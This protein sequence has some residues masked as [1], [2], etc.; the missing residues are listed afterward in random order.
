MITQYTQISFYVGQSATPIS[1]LSNVSNVDKIYDIDS[2]GNYIGYL[3][4]FS[5][6][7]FLQGLT[8][9]QPSTGYIVVTKSS[10]TLP[11]QLFPDETEI[12]TDTE[13]A[14]V[15]GVLQGGIDNVNLFSNAVFQTLQTASGVL[16]GEITVVSGD[17]SF[18]S[19]ELITASGALRDSIDTLDTSVTDLD[20]K[21]LNASG[22]LQSQVTSNSGNI[23]IVSGIMNT[24]IA[25]L[26]VDVTNL[27]NDLDSVSGEMINRVAASGQAALDHSATVSGL[28]VASSGNLSNRI[29]DNVSNISFVS[30]EIITASGALKDQ[31]DNITVDLAPTEGRIDF[32]SGELIT[33]SGALRADITTAESDIDFVS[34]ELITASGALRTDVDLKATDIMSIARSGALQS[35]T[36]TVSGIL[37]I[38][39]T[40]ASGALN[41]DMIASGT[42]LQSQITTIEN[43]TAILAILQDIDDIIGGTNATD[44]NAFLTSVN[45]ASA[46]VSGEIITAS[47]ALRAD[48]NLKATEVDSVARSG[49]LQSQITTAS[50]ALQADI[51]ALSSLDLEELGNLADILGSN[52]DLAALISGMESDITTNASDID[53]VSGELI[54]A[55]G[56]LRSGIN[57]VDTDVISLSGQMVSLTDAAAQSLNFNVTVFND[58][59]VNK[60]RFNGCGTTDDNNPDLYLHKGLTYYLNVDAATHP[61]WIKTESGIGTDNVQSDG[62]TNNGAENGTVIFTVPQDAPSILYYNCQYHELMAGKIYTA[63]DSV[64]SVNGGLA[65]TYSPFGTTT[66]PPTATTTAAPTYSNSV[67]STGAGLVV[68]NAFVGAG[69]EFMTA[70][71][72]YTMNWN[73]SSLTVPSTWA[74]SSY[75]KHNIYKNGVNVVSVAFYALGFL[76]DTD[77]PAYELELPD[78]STYTI[79]WNDGTLN[80]GDVYDVNL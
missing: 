76:N 51:D 25:A 69:L 63:V 59:G 38:D 20:T 15:S 36:T 28:L 65:D 78:G 42:S 48:V 46:F 52:A 47:G 29:S 72:G 80:S 1:G 2:N 67:S 61:F 23:D 40:T 5:N 30:G 3:D 10:A 4:D 16:D 58:N 64:P 77:N 7:P 19:G 33:A 70:A 57:E 54:T 14:A 11:Y 49:N 60:Y 8:N 6:L 56:A 73:T 71:T 62:V 45:N 50:G 34:G 53:F 9:L 75:R 32:V 17:M 43:D 39:I 13:L 26:N 44:L 22:Y 55:S 27:E 68:D 21:Y 18:V 66:V 79:G 12:T 41:A 35:Y 74:S 31:I 37:D 24:D